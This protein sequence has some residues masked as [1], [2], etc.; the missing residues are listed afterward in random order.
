MPNRR[1]VLIGIGTLGS[2]VS[3]AGCL[4]NPE[5]TLFVEDRDGNSVEDAE[6]EIGEETGFLDSYEVV[7]EGVTD[8]SGEF[9]TELDDGE[10]IITVSHSVHGSEELTTEIEN[11]FEESIVLF[12]D[13]V[14]TVTNS[15][16]DPVE[17]AEVEIIEEGGTF[18]GDSVIQTGTTDESGEFIG[19]FE[20][21]DGDIGR[22]NHPDYFEEEFTITSSEHT[23]PLSEFDS[24]QYA[25]RI[26]DDV[27]DDQTDYDEIR[28]INVSESDEGIIVEAESNWMALR[29]SESAY[30]GKAA[31]ILEDIFTSD[32]DIHYFEIDIYGPTVDEYGEEGFSRALTVGMYEE[33]ANQINWDNYDSDNLSRHAD[34][35]NLNFALF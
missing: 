26:T 35:Y 6:V 20:D 11:D 27:L 30:A 33:T 17:D 24:E 18:S 10:Y 22:I 12:P 32:A 31:D 15:E 23:I 4:E 21:G 3:L 8:N 14:L 28:G 1:K 19:N 9:R 25:R 34:T 2:T 29:S 13:L 16:S 7:E 5:I